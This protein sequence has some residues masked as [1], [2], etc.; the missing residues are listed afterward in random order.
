MATHTAAQR[1]FI[2]TRLAAFHTNSE[3]VEQ[4]LANWKDTACAD[5]DV[6]VVRHTLP[7]PE[8]FALFKA[9]R[10]EVLAELAE[11]WPDATETAR[12]NLLGLTRDRDS[13]RNRGAFELASELSEKIDKIE[14]KFFA[15]KSKQ[16]TA[17]P[18]DGAPTDEPITWQIVE[19]A[20][21]A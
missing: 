5:A 12:I 17:S 1:A 18:K 15:P 11:R 4:F 19:P 16:V 21:D 20:G 10:A 13:C 6:N 3:I 7:S 2:L 9:K 8:D 14:S